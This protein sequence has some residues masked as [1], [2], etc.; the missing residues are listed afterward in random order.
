MDRICDGVKS[1]K[2][3]EKLCEMDY[4]DDVLTLDKA[5]EICRRMEMTEE[6]LKDKDSSD[7]H[8]FQA[9][10]SSRGRDR[11]RGSGGHGRS[12]YPPTGRLLRGGV[13]QTTDCS[14]QKFMK[15]VPQ[16]C[17][18][19]ACRHTPSITNC[20]AYGTRCGNCDKLT[21]WA[22]CCRTMAAPLDIDEVVIVEVITLDTDAVLDHTVE[23][24]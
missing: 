3:K 18:Y 17:V 1:V 12:T 21:H 2:I 24:M 15:N 16:N 9:G 10:Y 7:V 4:G 19:C 14:Q 22:R 23:F 8:A 5:I 11:K 13:G 6:H 20:P